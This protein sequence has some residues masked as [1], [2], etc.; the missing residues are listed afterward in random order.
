MQQQ[1]AK[2]FLNYKGRK[3]RSN[4]FLGLFWQYMFG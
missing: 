1:K 4:T 2:F 3:I